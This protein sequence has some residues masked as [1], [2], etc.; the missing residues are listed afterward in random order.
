MGEG[1]K[2]L[3]EEASIP[4]RFVIQGAS[5]CSKYPERFA[6][7][8][9]SLSLPPYHASRLSRPPLPLKKDEAKKY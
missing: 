8:S 6:F 3:C 1:G 2:L 7:S 5:N 4:C 9:S